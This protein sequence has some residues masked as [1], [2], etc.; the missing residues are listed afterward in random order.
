VTSQ[1]AFDQ[2][3][4]YLQSAE[5]RMA[6]VL[7]RRLD[8]EADWFADDVVEQIELLQD[9]IKLTR[10]AL[11]QAEGWLDHTLNRLE[12]EESEDDDTGAGAE[13]EGEG[14]ALSGD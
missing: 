8:V 14:P 7:D 6:V 3:C 11:S 2:A 12:I 4:D 13:R 1:E 5:D 10:R 9:A